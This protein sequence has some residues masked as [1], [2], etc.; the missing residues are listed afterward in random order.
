ML[1]ALGAMLIFFGLVFTFNCGRVE[2]YSSFLLQIML[3][4]IFIGLGLQLLNR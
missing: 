3:G 4:P 2:N 1:K